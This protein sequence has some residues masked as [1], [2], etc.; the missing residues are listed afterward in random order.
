MNDDIIENLTM[1]VP[2]D[3]W[4]WLRVGLWAAAGLAILIL[5]IRRLHRQGRLPF[6]QTLREWPHET[7]LRDLARLRPLIAD[8]AVREFVT[9]ISAILRTYI[10]ARFELQ[11]PYL[12]TEEF[13]IVAEQSDRL[14]AEHRAR[15]ARFLQ[16]CDAV[17]FAL[18]FMEVDAM[19]ELWTAADGFVRE[20][21]AK[22]EEAAAA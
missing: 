14:E 2:A 15:L 17:K 22:S 19:E 9:A 8:G 12:S 5:I 7:A 4:M 1:V 10:E 16:S 20:T 6:F 18:R 11:A 21:I 13:L 3:P